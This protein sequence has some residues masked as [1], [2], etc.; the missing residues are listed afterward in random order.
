MRDALNDDLSERICDLL[1]IGGG[2]AGMAGAINAAAEGLSTIVLERAKQVGGQASSSSRIENY[3]GFPDGL[4]GAELGDYA[5]RQ[6]CRLGA[7]VHTESHVIDLRTVEGEHHVTCHGGQ[8]YRCKA[9]LISTGVMYRTLDV[10]G[11]SGLLNRGVFYGLSPRKAS[12]YEGQTVYIVGGANSAGQAAIHLADHGAIVNVLT[13]SPLSKGMSAYLLE[14][15]TAHPNIYIRENARV[16]AVHPNVEG[17]LAGV[18]ISTPERLSTEA[19]A[20]LFI[21]IGAEPRTDW[22]PQLMKDHRGY[23][24]TGEKKAAELETSVPGVYAAG[25]VR[26]GNIKRVATA[27]GEGSQAIQYVYRR[28]EVYV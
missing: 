12:L 4:S 24:V 2:P 26:S 8:L 15:I 9:V 7:E 3:L 13:R 19:A 25:D 5:Y 27:S 20:G 6:A 21:F 28:L 11:L 1:I 22:A 23:L 18:V 16:A 17:Y 10:P 14:R